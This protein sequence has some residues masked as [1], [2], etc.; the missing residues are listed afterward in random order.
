MILGPELTS[1]EWMAL[2]IENPFVKA[3]SL[4][5]VKYQKQVF[6]PKSFLNI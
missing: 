5:L 1:P 4:R 3:Q 6:E 2:S